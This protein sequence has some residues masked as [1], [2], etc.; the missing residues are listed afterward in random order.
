MAFERFWRMKSPPCEMDLEVVLKKVEVVLFDGV[1]RK[2]FWLLL[3]LFWSFKCMPVMDI[4]VL[5][6]FPISSGRFYIG[7]FLE[8]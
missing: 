3:P 8:G 7:G 1:T 4:N 6:P 2:R 5:N